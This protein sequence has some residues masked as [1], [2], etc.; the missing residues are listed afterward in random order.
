MIKII[1]FVG[2]VLI[3][4]VAL[5]VLLPLLIPLPSV[6]VDPA[7]FAE[8][9]S[10]FVRINSLETYAVQRGPLDGPPVV[11]LHGWGA[12]TFSWREN[13]D[14]LAEAGYRVVAYDRPPY[15]LSTKTG[16]IPYTLDGQARFLVALLDELGIEQAALVGNSAGGFLAG[17]VAARHPERVTG[18]VLV[19]GVPLPPDAFP[20]GGGGGGRFGLPSFVTALLDYP[21]GLWWARQAVRAFIEPDFITDILVTAYHDPAFVTPEIIAGYQRPLQVRDWDIA[22]VGQVRGMAF[23]GAALT[24]D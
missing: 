4:V 9:G 2:F 24:A 6:G 10:F 11:L 15:G 18:I 14:A 16:D 20:R 21:P 1:R 13:I 5:F 12:S 8:P 7:R 17:Y 19:D 3:I 23:C 22:L